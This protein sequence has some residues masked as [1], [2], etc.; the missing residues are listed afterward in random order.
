MTLFLPQLPAKKL[1][2][3]PKIE[4]LLHD[5]FYPIMNIHTRGGGLLLELH[6]I[7]MFADANDKLKQAR[8]RSRGLRAP[9]TRH[10]LGASR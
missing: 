9:A 4:N 1:F 3:P 8:H 10:P 7:T 5:H 2:L 6:T